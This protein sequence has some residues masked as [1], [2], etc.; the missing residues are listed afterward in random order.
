[1]V[2]SISALPSGNV[3]IVPPLVYLLGIAPEGPSDGRMLTE[4]LTGNP[5]PVGRVERGRR[6][7]Q[8]KLA[9]GIWSQYLKFTELEGVRYLDEGNGQWTKQ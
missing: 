3:D 1:M 9:G 4:A 8:V 5:N 2:S 6:D 7:T